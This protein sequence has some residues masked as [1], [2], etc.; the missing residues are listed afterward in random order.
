MD[1][2]LLKEIEKPGRYTGGEL[3]S[4]QK[5]EA[6]VR[7]ALCF[8]DVYEVG[9]SHLGLQIL[10]EVLNGR[11]GIA[12][13]RFFCPWTDMR[14]RLL[15]TGTPLSS[16]ETGRPLREFDI[17]GFSLSYELSYASVLA[18]LELGG[19]PL[20]ATDRGEADPIVL[21]GGQCTTNPEPMADFFDL[22]VIGEG[23]EA[24]AEVAE[25]VRRR[26]KELTRTEFL[27]E[28]SRIPGVYV[29]SLYT[30]ELDADGR[31]I[32][33]EAAEGAP[34][35]VRRRF[36]ADFENAPAV[37]RPVV[38][39]LATVHDR[40]VLEIMR[41]CPNGCRF[42]Q[43]GFITRP[44]RERSAERNLACAKQI[45]D[46]SGWEEI[47][48]CSLSSGD[49]SEIVPLVDDLIE[50]HQDGRVS[51]SLPSLRMDSFRLAAQAQEVR[52]KGLTFA[53]EAGT[54]R[55]RDV[56]NKNI[57]DAEILEA[58]RSAFAAGATHIKLYFMVGL[59]TETEADLDGIAEMVRQI[60]EAFYE[61]PKESRRGRLEIVVSVSNFV[62]KAGTPFQWEA[63][64]TQ[65]S[66][67]EK[68][69][70]L[71]ERLKMRG[72]R[73]H[74]HDPKT[75]LLEAALARG[76]RRLG[77]MLLEAYK[78][79]AYLD[80]WGEQ[81]SFDRYAEAFAA[82]GLDPADIA[83]RKREAGGLMPYD[84]IDQGISREFLLRERRRALEERTTPACSRSCSACGLEE[85]GCPLH[86][87]HCS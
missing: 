44:V 54:Q 62:P 1:T 49:Y 61:V 87:A 43:A 20:L 57:T 22:F 82:C 10:Y 71:R 53:P 42:C 38:P 24:D 39:Y 47:G 34:A 58:A 68:H 75:S 3:N 41:G 11:D 37:T 46:A 63:Q 45:L 36:V 51:V 76:D 64:D 83:S 23:E 29:P 78:R 52:K 13:E 56:I 28:A 73:F 18:M 7:F 5:D 48:L 60:R 26:R 72:V 9:M 17:V 40:G 21:G 12:A 79:G 30:P 35:A 67:A 69:R 84:H 55:L 33:I 70:Y 66:F 2:K 19:V 81:F 14:G 65:E 16:L 85:A 50:Q 77:A 31:V 25:L 86:D 32:R 15:E 59:P 4:I 74:Y 6:D 80:A 27:R 8:P